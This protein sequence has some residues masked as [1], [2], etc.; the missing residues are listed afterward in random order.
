MPATLP[1]SSTGLAS[2][3]HPATTELWDNAYKALKKKEEDLVNSYEK[4]LLEEKD[5]A[6]TTDF[7]NLGASE[8]EQKGRAL[9]EK[10]LQEVDA[11][12]LRI[13]FGNEEVVV[14]EQLDRIFKIGL[15]AKDFISSALSA[16]PHAA[17]AWAGVC[18]L[19]PV[20][21]GPS[22]FSVL[23]WCTRKQSCETWIDSPS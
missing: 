21:L 7:G 4:I 14:R 5:N 17:L 11:A 8:R 1:R 15:S 18:V 2:A 23:V 19:L 6:L 20:S 12:R 9:I 13:S 22:L 3:S 16:D 10:T